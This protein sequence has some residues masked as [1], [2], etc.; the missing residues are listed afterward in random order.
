[1]RFLIYLLTAFV[2]LSSCEESANSN[3]K[4]DP[5][6]K[7]ENL[8]W[9]KE[10][11][12]F[13]DKTFEKGQELRDKLKNKWNKIEINGFSVDD[14]VKM[15]QQLYDEINS[16]PDYRVV[17]KETNQKLYDY[18]EGIKQTILANGDFRYKDKFEWKITVLNDDNTINAFCAPGG[19]I[20]VYTGI[21]KYLD[22]EA[23]FAGVLAH[24]MGHA[25]RRHGTR[26]MT[27][28]Y[29][30]QIVLDFVMR[31]ENSD[32]F[33]QVI[34]GLLSLRYSRSYEREADECSV[35]Y[36][37]STT[38]QSDGAA[39][40]FEKIVNEKGERSDELLSTHPDPS[41]RIGTF[42]SLK[43]KMNCQG[44]QSFVE[45]YRIIKKLRIR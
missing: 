18:I 15:G 38:Y 34:G 12:E 29:G 6:Y 9:S 1:M 35:R 30:I 20:F 40:F 36:L 23:E 19:Y 44:K 22:N 43:K 31:G 28:T 7:T 4:E 45:R 26:Q 41:E 11:N 25:E 3:V 8:D 39:G 42:H 5:I 37:C 10:L 14:D 13:K 27:K 33:K 24:E 2:V 32:H 21:L 16:S 17:P